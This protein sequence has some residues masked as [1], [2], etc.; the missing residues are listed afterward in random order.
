MP[1]PKCP[2]CDK[3][4]YPTEAVNTDQKAYHKACFRCKKCKTSLNIKNYRFYE[5]SLWC[6]THLPKPKATIV[7]DDKNVLDRL[8]APKKAIGEGARGVQKDDA[9]RDAA[10]AAAA[11]PKKKAAGSAASTPQKEDANDE[12]REE[13]YEAEAEAEAE[14]EPEAAAPESS[15]LSA[16]EE[17]L[18]W[19]RRAGL[20]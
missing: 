14:P 3:T 16:E 1:G 18:A 5:G 7:A 11:T 13:Q 4:V 17:E 12:L 9:V 19:K 20:I 2:V 8:N 6:V 10:A 15:G